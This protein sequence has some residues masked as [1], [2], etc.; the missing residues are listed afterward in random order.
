MNDIVWSIN[1][2]NDSMKKILQRMEN[3]AR[4]LLQRKNIAFTFNYEPALLHINLRME[5]RNNFYRLFKE[6]LNNVLKYSG[7]DNLRVDIK[8][9]H[10]KVNFTA[11]GNGVGF[12]MG[13]MKVLAAKSL[14]GNGLV[15]MQRRA[16]EKKGEYFITS[17]PGEGTSVNL[18]FPVE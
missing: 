3:F 4:P 1:P 6:A 18:I 12:D 11:T 8:V 9:S 17:G 13:Q 15:N 7:A 10:H 16:K 5:K 2:R 14:S